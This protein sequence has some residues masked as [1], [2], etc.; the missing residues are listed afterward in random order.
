MHGHHWRRCCPTGGRCPPPLVLLLPLLRRCCAGWSTDVSVDAFVV[1][2]KGVAD[3]D[4]DGLLQP[5]LKRWQAKRCTYAVF[6]LPAVQ[7]S[8]LEKRDHAG[9]L[10]C[11]SG[12]AG[13]APCPNTRLPPLVKCMRDEST[14]QAVRMWLCARGKTQG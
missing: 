3:P 6:A 11:C 13:H 8:R 9:V 10:V 5:L 14:Y 7:V 1:T 12:A 2:V 4:Q